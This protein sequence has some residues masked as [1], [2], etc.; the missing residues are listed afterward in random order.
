VDLVSSDSV[1][2]A[3]DRRN[4]L[5]LAVGRTERR[6][7]SAL[8][9]RA[10]ASAPMAALTKRFRQSIVGARNRIGLQV[11]RGGNDRHLAESSLP[12]KSQGAAGPCN[13]RPPRLHLSD[14]VAASPELQYDADGRRLAR[15]GDS[16]DRPCWAAHDNPA[17]TRRRREEPAAPATL[18]ANASAAS[19]KATTRV[20]GTLPP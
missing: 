2:R 20:D 1:Q 11:G 13:G 17:Q 18:D 16:A 3:M 15:L 14:H 6:R 19:V 10:G 9:G 8:N 5:V 7:R 12:H 4:Y